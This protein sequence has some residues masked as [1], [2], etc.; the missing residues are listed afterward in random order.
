MAIDKDRLA[1]IPRPGMWKSRF[2]QP[3]IVPGQGG[4][5]APCVALL[6]SLAVVLPSLFLRI[7]QLDTLPGINGDEAFAPVQLAEMQRGNPYSLRTSLGTPFNPLHSGVV[8]LVNA[9]AEP[10]FLVLRIPGLIYGLLTLL[11]AFLLL[12]NVLAERVAL[13]SALLISALPLHIAYARMSDEPSLVPL[14]SLLCLYFACGGSRLKAAFALLAAIWVYPSCVFLLPLLAAPFAPSFV[15]SIRERRLAAVMGDV[16]I[17]A[18]ALIVS[19]LMVPDS[20]HSVVESLIGPALER[21]YDLGEA[22]SFVYRFG[23]LLSGVTV[24]RRLTGQLSGLSLNLHVGLVWLIGAP[25]LFFGLR[26][27]IRERE[28]SGLL[29]ASGFALSLLSFYLV[30]GAG[31]LLPGLER[32]ACMFTVPACVVFALC[33]DRAL[34]EARVASASSFI[35]AGI[36]VLMLASLYNHLFLTL[37][38]E[39]WHAHRAYQTGPDEPKEVA[40]RVILSLRDPEKYTLVR[41]QD[42]WLYWPIRY[43]SQ[44]RERLHVSIFQKPRRA[45]FPADHWSR[46]FGPDESETYAVAYPDG[47]M[48]RQLMASGAY[49]ELQEIRGYQDYPVLV[50]LKKSS[51]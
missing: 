14:M 27:M 42:W 13:S 44:D 17:V 49:D 21:T 32:H 23:N 33:L 25:V 9:V 28:A 22:G 29:L 47:R 4:G 46:D 38:A 12:R 20:R 2:W 15:A 10:S 11:L 43:L 37:K 34:A 1:F 50:L 35:A 7:Y 16:A 19:F 8:M 31:H 40:L 30:T 39:P 45:L 41:T 48:H 5:L 26:R 6:V 3:R 24:Y 51:Q 36:S 18:V